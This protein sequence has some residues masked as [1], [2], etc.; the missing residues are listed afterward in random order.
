MKCYDRDTLKK[1][2][3]DMIFQGDEENSWYSDVTGKIYYNTTRAK[4]EQYETASERMRKTPSIY[5]GWTSEGRA[6]A[7]AGIDI[8][9]VFESQ[10]VS[11]IPEDW[12][13]EMAKYDV[14]ASTTAEPIETDNFENIPDYIDYDDL[15]KDLIDLLH[16]DDKNTDDPEK[17]ALV[18]GLSA[19]GWNGINIAT[20]K[21]DLTTEGNAEL[22]THLARY[23]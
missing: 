8:S 23:Y 10:S 7:D 17:G 18:E 21:N 14:D 1:G 13:A 2:N 4:A 22:L 15:P 16:D 9:D 19:D 5:R 12:I 6:K 20:L 11:D 3:K